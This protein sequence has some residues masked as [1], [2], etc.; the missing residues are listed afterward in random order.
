MAAPVELV[1]SL[2]REAKIDAQIIDEAGEPLVSLEILRQFP[3]N[4]MRRLFEAMRHPYRVGHFTHIHKPIMD[5]FKRICMEQVLDD[6]KN[7]SDN[8]PAEGSVEFYLEVCKRYGFKKANHTIKD[9]YGEEFNTVARIRAAVEPIIT[10]VVTILFSELML[11]VSSQQFSGKGAIRDFLDTFEIEMSNV[12]HHFTFS[13]PKNV[14]T[15]FRVDFL[16]RDDFNFKFPRTVDPSKGTQYRKFI[17]EFPYECLIAITVLDDEV[18][19]EKWLR[20]ATNWIDTESGEHSP[21]RQAIEQCLF[22]NAHKC[23]L[24]ITDEVFNKYSHEDYDNTS[25]TDIFNFWCN[26]P[27]HTYTSKRPFGYLG[28]PDWNRMTLNML[29]TI[30]KHPLAEVCEMEEP[31]KDCALRSQWIRMI[32]WQK[33][34]VLVLA[35]RFIVDL[36]EKVAERECRA[37]FAEDGSAL[38]LGHVAREG[39]AASA[40][41]LGGKSVNTNLDERSCVVH[42]AG[43]EF[44]SLIQNSLNLVQASRLRRLSRKSHSESEDSEEDESQPEKRARAVR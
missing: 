6:I 9:E 31:P 10:E 39:R 35:R 20:L 29:K 24:F 28:Q 8:M 41:L 15:A 25:Y 26:Y 32:R 44:N 38:M 3:D 1:N 4:H 30:Y 2:V 22:N 23:L 33:V 11:F 7:T 12:P 40:A 27:Q 18:A 42:G 34:R 19:M 21:L 5:K 17:N 14:F 16:K 36:M 37:E 13:W 43:K